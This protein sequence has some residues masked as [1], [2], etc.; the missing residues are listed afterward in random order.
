M[1]LICSSV[2]TFCKQFNNFSSFNQINLLQTLDDEFTHEQ[3]I[4]TPYSVLI[5]ISSE[6]NITHIVLFA[7]FAFL[8]PLLMKNAN[9][10]FVI[11]QIFR[12]DSC[13]IIT[14]SPSSMLHAKPEQ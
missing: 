14:S 7:I 4:A 3:G 10:F 8:S 11:V 12:V 6:P 5:P 9:E 2:R 13:N 1:L